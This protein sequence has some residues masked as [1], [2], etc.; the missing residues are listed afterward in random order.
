M[1]PIPTSPAESMIKRVADEDPTTNMFSSPAIGFTARR[2]H[3]VEVPTPTKPLFWW[4]VRKVVEVP[5]SPTTKIGEVVAVGS[6]STE[7]DAHGVE[8]PMPTDGR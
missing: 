4:T 2:A 3:G 1:V 6:C 7:S 5:W 8:E